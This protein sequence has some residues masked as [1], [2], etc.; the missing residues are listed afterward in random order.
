MVKDIL[1]PK[2]MPTEKKLEMMSQ[3]ISLEAYLAAGHKE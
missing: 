2:Q 3:A 1:P